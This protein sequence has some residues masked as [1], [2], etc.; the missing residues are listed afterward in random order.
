MVC[1]VQLFHP[2]LMETLTCCPPARE[3]NAIAQAV[4][5]TVPGFIVAVC[6]SSALWLAANRASVQLVSKMWGSAAK[7]LPVFGQLI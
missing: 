2:S 7:T 6:G 5:K 1:Q 3:K 4:H